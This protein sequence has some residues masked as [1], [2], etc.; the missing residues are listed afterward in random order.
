LNRLLGLAGESL[1]ESR[2]LR[3]HSVAVARMKRLH[4]GVAGTLDQLRA[5]LD[6]GMP[7]DRLAEILADAQ[8]QLLR[9]REFMAHRLEELEA[10][11][12]RSTNLANRLYDEALQVRMRPFGDAIGGLARMVRDV[13]RHLGKEVRF[14]VIGEET[15]VDR[16]IIDKLEAPLGHLLRNSLDHGLEL[17]AERTAAGKPATGALKLEA[18]H[19]A[20]KLIVSVVDDGRGL[21]PE[22]L[23][24]T[25][26]RKKLV[27]PEMAPR[28]SEAEL[29]EFLFLPGFSMKEHVSEISGRG[30][31]LDVVQSMVKAVRGTV[32]VQNTLGQGMR[33]TLQLPLTLSVVR[34]LLA[35]IGGEPYA[36]PLGFITHTLRVEREAVATTEGRQHFEF[37]GQRIALVGAHEV[38]G[39]DVSAREAGGVPVI[40]LGEG[41]RRYGVA[42]EKFLGEHELVV[43]PLDPRLGKIQNIA[44]GALM[45]NG[46]PVLIV[47]VEDFVRSIEKV[48]QGGGR[49]NVSAAAGATATHERRKRVLIV[50]DSLTVRELER[51][52]LEARGYA[53][54]HAVDGMDGWNAVRA[55]NFDLVIS[56]VDMPRL[57]GIEL[58]KLIK[59][60]PRL[61]ALPVMIVSYKDREEDRRRGLDAG[62]DYYITKGSFH[63]TT[64]VD[65]VR[66]L[67]GEARTAAP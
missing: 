59:A 40:L 4:A 15:Q 32:R 41:D 33:V 44:A 8:R 45:D 60:D 52:L 34:S 53:V 56:D 64:M 25:V 46:E 58:T 17:P 19:S 36:F 67:I 66:D 7:P 43:H 35:E 22:R 39:R 13:A 30:V 65:A 55:G 26:V 10:F 20:G 11:D 14:Q 9:A 50:D 23:R 47:D 28:L 37:E 18:R 48:V 27:L 1:V 29:L 54:E 51:K 38:L 21:D 57:D 42:V 61:R 16:D 2:W 6:G 3:P 5:G 12:R 62:A 49:L 31:G 63:D 24:E